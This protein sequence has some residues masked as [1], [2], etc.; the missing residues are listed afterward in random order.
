MDI[1]PKGKCVKCNPNNKR[2]KKQQHV[3]AEQ[4]QGN[5]LSISI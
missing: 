5:A 2:K 1:K 3:N 4:T